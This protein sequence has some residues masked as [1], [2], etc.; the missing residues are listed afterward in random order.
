VIDPPLAVVLVSGGLDSCVAAVIAAR[1]RR[2]AFLHLNYRQRTEG[3]ELRAFEELAAHFHVSRRL[4]V[5]L[6]FMEQIGGSSLVDPG[7]TIPEEGEDGDQVPS[8]YVPFRNANFLGIAVAWAEVIGAADIFIGAHEEGSVYPDCRRE[9]FSAYNSAITAGTRP[10]SQIQVRTP[11][12]AMDK[13][14]IVRTGLELDA[15]FQLTWSC[16]QR[17]DLACGRCHSCRL[18]LRGFHR[19]GAEDPIPYAARHPSGV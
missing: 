18:R 12:I 19:L 5:D 1:D 6:P 10:D 11:L 14:A 3:R 15:P 2:L 9:F 16:Y 13:T 7:L 4:A 17:S 8:T